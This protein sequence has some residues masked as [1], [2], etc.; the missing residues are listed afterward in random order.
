MKN[1]DAP[2]SQLLSHEVN[3]ELNMLRAMMM[4]GVGREIDCRDMVIVDNGGLRDVKEQL[5][6]KLP[7]PRAL[8]DDI[9]HNTILSLNTGAGYRGLSIRRPRYKR[10]T[11]VDEVAGSA[12]TGVDTSPTYLLYQ[13]LLPL[14]WTLTCMIS[15]KLTRTDAVFSRTAMMLFYV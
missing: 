2:K 12:A 8:G 3:V 5:L 4:N 13:T 15:M 11:Q 14:F 7:K 6:E 9:G 10:G 1:V